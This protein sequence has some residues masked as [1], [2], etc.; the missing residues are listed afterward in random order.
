VRA[1]AIAASLWL[2]VMY[3]ST[4]MARRARDRLSRYGSVD[5]V[6]GSYLQD[7]LVLPTDDD[8]RTDPARAGASR[9]FAGTVGVRLPIRKDVPGA[10]PHTPRSPP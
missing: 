3:G 9:A 8:W 10:P 2:L 5:S 4:S 6:L 7:W 1:V